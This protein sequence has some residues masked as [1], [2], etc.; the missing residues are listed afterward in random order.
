[1][2]SFLEYYNDADLNIGFPISEYQK[3]KDYYNILLY[4]DKTLEE[5]P[6]TD[7]ATHHIANSMFEILIRK[8]TRYNKLDFLEDDDLN[9]KITPWERSS[10]GSKNATSEIFVPDYLEQIPEILKALKANK[11]VV[12]NEIIHILNFKYNGINE[13][14]EGD[15]LIRQKLKRK[16]VIRLYKLFMDKAFT[17][18]KE[19]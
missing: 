6:E 7:L 16:L 10:W 18:T 1:M 5:S 9:I 2:S 3:C 19:I 13:R 15:D 11:Q 8:I 4:E 12:V 17:K 14:I